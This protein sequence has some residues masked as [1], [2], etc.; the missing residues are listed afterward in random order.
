MRGR[1]CRLGD[2]EGDATDSGCVLILQLILG[3]L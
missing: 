1:G 3:L 2:C